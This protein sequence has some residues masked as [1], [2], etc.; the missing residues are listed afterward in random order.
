MPLRSSTDKLLCQQSRSYKEC[1]CYL[2]GFG[3]KDT[4]VV[5]VALL[6]KTLRNKRSEE[7]NR[8]LESER[9]MQN[10]QRTDGIG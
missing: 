7:D 6:T 9:G 1:K 8:T 4:Q 3:V 2:V 10:G 5:F